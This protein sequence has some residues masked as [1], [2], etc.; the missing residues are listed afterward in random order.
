MAR[1][2][3][4]IKNKLSYI[5]SNVNILDLLMEFERTLDSVNLYA[6]KNWMEGE[7]VEGPIIDRY[8]VTVKLMFP[9]KLMPDPNGGMRLVKLGCKV[10]FEEDQFKAPVKITGRNSYADMTKKK[11]KVKI[12]DVWIVT[13]VMPKRYLDERILDTIAS[14]GD[15]NS[16]VVNTDDI[17]QAYDDS[18]SSVDDMGDDMGGMD[19]GMDAGMGDEEMGGQM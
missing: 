16:L 19:T 10:N 2:I 18:V 11:A 13:I 1:H 12:H 3:D 6:Y 14:Y 9:K 15:K 5:H 17:S 7:I 8:W 4:E